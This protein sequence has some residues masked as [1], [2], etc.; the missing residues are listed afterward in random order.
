MTINRLLKY[1]ALHKYAIFID[2]M[3][4]NP[5]SNGRNPINETFTA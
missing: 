2:N 5:N 4:F 1:R 3:S